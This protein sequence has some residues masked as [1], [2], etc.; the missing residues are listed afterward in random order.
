MTGLPGFDFA[1]NI[2]HD[3]AHKKAARPRNAGGRQVGGVEVV[4]CRWR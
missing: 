4:S 1:P 2:G 3:H